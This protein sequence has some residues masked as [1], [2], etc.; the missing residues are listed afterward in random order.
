MLGLVIGDHEA[1]VNDAGDPA[2][3]RQQNAQEETKEA[4]G[5]QHGDGRKND[6]EEV[7]ESF[8]IEVAERAQRGP[9]LRTEGS[10][11]SKASPVSDSPV[12]FRSSRV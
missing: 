9:D 1:G 11:F 10:T 3:Q 7:A 12:L 2:G 8:Q 4:P 5:Q 6:A